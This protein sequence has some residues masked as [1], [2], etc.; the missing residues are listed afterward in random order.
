MSFIRHTLEQDFF[1]QL[2]TIIINEIYQV[3]TEKL[4]SIILPYFYD[5]SH[6]INY[7]TI[8]SIFHK[9]STKWPLTLY[10]KHFTLKQIKVY[11]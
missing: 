3:S 6:I 1:I 10:I 5:F 7:S 9:L 11:T 8:R 2:L 4:L